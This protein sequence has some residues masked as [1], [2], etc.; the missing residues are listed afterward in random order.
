[1]GRLLSEIRR[2]QKIA[3]LLTEDDYTIPDNARSGDT[4]EMGN[5]AEEDLDLSDTPEFNKTPNLWDEAFRDFV[6]D[7]IGDY[8]EHKF[9]ATDPEDV[10]DIV[11]QYLQNLRYD[12]VEALWSD[13][14]KDKRTGLKENDIDLSDTPK[15]ADEK[16]Q[17]YV[18]DIEGMEP[19]LGPYTLEHARRVIRG[20]SASGEDYGI[21][22]GEVAREIWNLEEDID[23]S[24]TPQFSRYGK[25]KIQREFQKAGID[26]KRPIF[27]YS[28]DY[29]MVKWS[30]DKYIYELVNTIDDLKSD[31]EYENLYG[32]VELEIV[33]NPDDVDP[34]DYFESNVKDIKLVVS[35]H[36]AVRDYIFQ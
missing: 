35:I 8:H 18:Y 29:G 5:I 10:S 33:S 22:N 36:E 19:P 21:V 32:D 14:I 30:V 28:I 13:Y 16:K 4:A 17:F 25:S 26:F 9:G 24:D 34:L 27:V 2:F 23:L 15:F 6:W 20:L 12:E 1:M 11:G 3:G 7:Y 31:P